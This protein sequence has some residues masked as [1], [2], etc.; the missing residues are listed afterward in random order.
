LL[1]YSYQQGQQQLAKEGQDWASIDSLGSEG[2]LVTE[3]GASS[4]ICNKLEKKFGELRERIRE[5]FGKGHR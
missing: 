3:K 2:L 5:P 4:E 1:C